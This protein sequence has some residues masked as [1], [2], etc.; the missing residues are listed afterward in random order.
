MAKQRIIDYF[1]S[2][3]EDLGVAEVLEMVTSNVENY[4]QQIT[5][6]TIIIHYDIFDADGDKFGFFAM[7]SVRYI[8]E[9]NFKEKVYLRW[10]ND[11]EI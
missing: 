3:E 8:S 11:E 9:E 4:E 6:G 5:A 2:Q 1:K 10:I 7:G